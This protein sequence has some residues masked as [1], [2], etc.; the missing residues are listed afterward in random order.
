MK[1][2]NTSSTAISRAVETLYEVLTEIGWKPQKDEETAG[3]VVNFDPPYIPVAY[4]YAAISAE[5]EMFV[6]YLNF[7]VAAAAERR[8][9]T[10]RFLTL[11][12]W[13]L[14]NGDFE[15]DYEDGFVRFRSSVAF[16]EA[17][18]SGVLIR[19]VIL[20]AMNAIERYADGAIDVMARGKSAEQA[21]KEA[22]DSERLAED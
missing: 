16:Q 13:N 17:E 1:E 4:A 5:L 21:F 2:N 6:F 11:A 20:F 9:E 10:A 8:D 15:M 19:N 14:M 18:L 22:A 12:N 7:G 3:F